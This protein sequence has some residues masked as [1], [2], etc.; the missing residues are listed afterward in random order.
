MRLRPGR[1]QAID[2]FTRLKDIDRGAVGPVGQ[3]LAAVGYSRS[4]VREGPGF[5]KRGSVRVI[6]LELEHKHS[7]SIAQVGRVAF[8]PPRSCPVMRMSASGARLR[9]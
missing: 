9:K 6:D 7:C 1:P 2:Q 3:E 8:T 4:L 5:L